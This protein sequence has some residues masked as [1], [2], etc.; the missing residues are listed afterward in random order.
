[1]PRIAILGAS[2]FLGSQILIAFEAKDWEVVTFSWTQSTD[3]L[4]KE[5]IADLFDEATLRSAVSQTNPDVVLSTAWDTEHGKF[6][7]NESNTAYRDVTLRIAEL[8][9]GG[10]SDK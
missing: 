4:R 5:I 9:S 10:V 7:T 6:W 2:G 1:M 3:S 8:S